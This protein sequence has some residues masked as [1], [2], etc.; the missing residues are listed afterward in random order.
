VSIVL[1]NLVKRYDNVPIV[2]GVS[3]EVK[4][5]ELFVL[6]GPSGSGKSTI[7]RL[8]AGLIPLDGGKIVLEGRDVTTLAP[9]ERGTGFVFQNYSIFRHMTVSQNIQLGLKIRKA[10]AAD[11]VR[12]SEELLEMVGLAGLG[13]RRADQLSGGQQQRVALARALAYEPTVLLLDEPFGALD[14]KIRVQLRRTLKELRSR[15]SVTTILVTHDQ[16]EAFDLADRVGIMERGELLDVG[17][18]EEIYARPRTPFTATF[19]GAGNV[20]ISRATSGVVHLG[21]VAVPLPA[22]M[23]AED[24]KNVQILIRPEH[25]I[26]SDAGPVADAHPLGEG[27][28]VERAFGG[29]HR[30]LRV[31]LPRLPVT[32][33]VQPIVPFGENAMLIDFA[34]PA[35]QAPVGDRVWV[36]F[37]SCHVIEEIHPQV[38]VLDDPDAPRATLE[39][40]RV[41]TERI[42]GRATILAVAS[43]AEGAEVVRA[44]ARARAEAAGFPKTID[45]RI[46][47]GN[48][49][50][51]LRVEQAEQVYD[52]TVIWGSTGLEQNQSRISRRVVEMLD[53]LR[54]P[55]LVVKGE[56][57]SMRKILIGSAAGEPGK[58]D[59]SAAGRLARRIGAAVVLV[60]VTREGAQAPDAAR[61]HL[62][63]AERAL[64]ALDVPVE[65]EIRQAPSPARGILDVAKTAECDLVVIGQHQP[66]ARWR[67]RRDDVSLQVCAAAD[68]SVLVLKDELE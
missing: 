2:D 8:I 38:L 53:H 30:R 22:S 62:Q 66:G 17:T 9:Q 29:M 31:R 42:R 50:D 34:I 54:N 32:R 16:E 46:R 7:L 15:L 18:P 60:H 61:D 36:G 41:L 12:K 57:T 40:A 10:P 65:V 47:F 45:P 24:D 48:A 33:Q 35:D 67:A 14:V 55:L 4:N 13:D 37:R 64:I 6:L 23:T 49:F 25:V 11:R 59:V 21:S 3:L 19:L 5:G 56:R 26:A 44:E 68:R 27:T 63:R 52:Y 39:V 58:A 1:E 28:I 51:Q 43:G 20:L